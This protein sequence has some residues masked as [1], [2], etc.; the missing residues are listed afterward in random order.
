M[1]WCATSRD[2]SKLPFEGKSVLVPQFEMED[3]ELEDA[4]VGLAAPSMRV[5]SKV[6]ARVG[7][8]DAQP[9]EELQN[10]EVVAKGRAA[11]LCS[12]WYVFAAC[13]GAALLLHAVDASNEAFLGYES[14]SGLESLT[15][16]TPLQLGKMQRTREAVFGS[17]KVAVLGLAGVCVAIACLLAVHSDLLN[18]YPTSAKRLASCAAESTACRFLYSTAIGCTSMLAVVVAALLL[19]GSVGVYALSVQEV[20]VHNLLL[21]HN[22]SPSPSPGSSPYPSPSPNPNPSPDP[23]PVPNPNQVC[24]FATKVLTP[25]VS[26]VAGLGDLGDELGDEVGERVSQLP[27]S[28]GQLEMQVR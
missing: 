27:H 11:R 5:E 21:D 24:G 19:A 18:A 2:K 3:E 20:Q 25:A 10:V 1:L 17:V 4:R 8:D 23:N 26:W 28:V 14:S 13:V 15:D 9:D 12:T 22:P 7:G 16:A 6:E